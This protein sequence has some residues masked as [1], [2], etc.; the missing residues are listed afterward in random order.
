MRLEGGDKM[1]GFFGKGLELLRWW[2]GNVHG[3]EPCFAEPD[4]PPCGGDV[5]ETDRGGWLNAHTEASVQAEACP[6]LSLRD[7]SPARGE[8]GGEPRVSPVLRTPPQGGRSGASHGSRPSFGPRR[9]GGDWRKRRISTI[10]I[11]GF[12]AGHSG[13]GCAAPTRLSPY[14]RAGCGGASSRAPRRPRTPAPRSPH[15]TAC[16]RARFAAASTRPD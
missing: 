4:H 3:F 5:S 15:R 6:P 12:R 7:I 2:G 9:K 11:S 1:A 14:P 10:L 13:K 16:S 8:I